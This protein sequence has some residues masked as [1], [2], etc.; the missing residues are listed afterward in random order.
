MRRWT[1]ALIVASALA[2]VGGPAAWTS[3]T[4]PITTNDAVSWPFSAK[5][6]GPHQLILEFAW[7]IADAQVESAVASARATTGA[8]DAPTFDFSWQLFREGQ[9]LSRRD[10]PQRSS[11]VIENRASELGEGPL[12]S[13]GLVF[14]GFDLEAGKTYTLRIVPGPDFFSV[15]RAAPRVLVM[16]QLFA[17]S[18]R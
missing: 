13:L 10:G 15:A 12:K 18:V 1:L 9:A 5:N 2:C 14:G 7:P 8:P 11:G 17:I 3:F 16:N 6:S 4:A